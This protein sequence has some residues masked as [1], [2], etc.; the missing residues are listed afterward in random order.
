MAE[1]PLLMEHCFDDF[2]LVVDGS[3]GLVSL[4]VAFAGYRIYTRSLGLCGFLSLSAVAGVAGWAWFKDDDQESSD[5]DV[6]LIIIS[7]CAFLWGI[8]GAA[9]CM[10]LGKAVHKTLGFLMGAAFGAVVVGLLIAAASASGLVKLPEVYS[11]WEAYSSVIV[12]V[13]AAIGF[14][15][16]TRNH[17]IYIIMASTAFLGS[18]VGTFLLNKVLSCKFDIHINAGI[19]LA[20]ALIIG[21]SAYVTQVKLTPE[22]KKRGVLMG[23]DQSSDEEEGNILE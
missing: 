5:Q 3:I 1:D 10:K 11:G 9:I 19:V 7:V 23:E 6:K 4:C 22:V 8:M 14:G 20:V 12:G 18:F 13:P 17:T 16:L 2:H 21:I 15:Y